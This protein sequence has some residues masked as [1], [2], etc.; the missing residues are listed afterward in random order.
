MGTICFTITKDNLFEVVRGKM[1]RGIFGTKEE[2]IRV[3]W[4]KLHN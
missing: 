3:G 1:L 2:E 4:R